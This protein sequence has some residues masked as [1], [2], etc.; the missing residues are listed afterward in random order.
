[1]KRR[2]VLIGVCVVA[3]LSSCVPVREYEKMYVDDA[4]MQLSSRPT[5]KTE[6]NFLLYREGSAG[7]NGSKTGGGCG[8]N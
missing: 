7:A 6:N 5:E 4:D 2:I 1:M 3:L 8:C